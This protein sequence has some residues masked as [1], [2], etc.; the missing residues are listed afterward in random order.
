M[1]KAK[2]YFA[3]QSRLV[4][5][6]LGRR[7][8]EVGCGLGNFTAMLL[9]R[10]AVIAVDVAE[11]CIK[12]L[13]ERYP[14]Q[15]NLHAFACDVDDP[16]FLD[17]ARLRPDSCICLNVLEHLED[18]QKALQR[19]GS[20][21]TPGGVIV[22]IIPAFAGLY[23]PI[24]QKLGHYRRYSRAAITALA[25]R[26]GLRVKK[27][28]YMNSIGLFGWWVNA[29]ILKREA[30]SETQIGFFDRF[31]VPPMSFL[32]GLKTPPFGQS[33]FGVLERQ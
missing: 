7:V 14:S 23:G 5:R 1:S 2:N 11:E 20:L 30:Q 12:R 3:W 4:I 6:E 32:E 8:V 25:E 9:D 21:L 16:A 24:D 15:A 17:L 33:L 29:H 26:S 18:D 28:H 19:M 10:D 22:V 31:I 27:T 13:K